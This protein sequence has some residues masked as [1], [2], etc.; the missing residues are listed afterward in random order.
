MEYLKEQK[1]EIPLQ[2]LMAIQKISIETN[3]QISKSLI[4]NVMETYFS[5]TVPAG[6]QLPPDTVCF[7]L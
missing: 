7:S 1:S 3:E 2:F 4:E 5:G 6:M